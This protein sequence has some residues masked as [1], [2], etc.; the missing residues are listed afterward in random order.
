[1]VVLTLAAHGNH[2]GA[3]RSNVRAT[4]QP[5]S[6]GIPGAGTPALGLRRQPDREPLPKIVGTLAL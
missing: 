1:M 2:P 5:S 4:S 3:L 6:A